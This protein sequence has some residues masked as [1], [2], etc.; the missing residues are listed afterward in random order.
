MAI[1]AVSARRPAMPKIRGRSRRG[2]APRA[3]SASL[4]VPVRPPW[5]WRS[6]LPPERG[7]VDSKLFKPTSFPQVSVG[8][9]AG[10]VSRPLPPAWGDRPVAC[11]W[12]PVPRGRSGWARKTARPRPGRLGGAG[13]PC[14]RLAVWR[15]PAPV[16]AWLPG[17]GRA[18]GRARASPLRRPYLSP[19]LVKSLSWLRI[20]QHS[21]ISASRARPRHITVIPGAPSPGRPRNPPSLAIQSAASFKLGA[22][23]GGVRH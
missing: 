19:H 17:R 6:G 16:T 1:P 23:G 20:C 10:L 12:F 14:P 7:V 21:V 11:W 15:L 22:V 9:P 8:L 3:G 18:Q 2:Y 5:R 13:S 4:P